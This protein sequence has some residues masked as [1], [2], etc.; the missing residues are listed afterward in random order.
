M[1]N[2]PNAPPRW[3]SENIG[4]GKCFRRDRLYI[5]GAATQAR[6]IHCGHPTV[7]WPWFIDLDG[8]FCGTFA[9]LDD[10]R[11]MAERVHSGATA[12]EDGHYVDV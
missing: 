4:P 11:A 6:V 10:A 9:H 1:A 12:I 5:D 2:P 7:L 8:K 3:R